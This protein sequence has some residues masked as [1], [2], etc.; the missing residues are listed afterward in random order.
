MEGSGILSWGTG[1][2]FFIEYGVVMVAINY[3]I[4]PFGK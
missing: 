4:G 3:R 1:P 2:Q